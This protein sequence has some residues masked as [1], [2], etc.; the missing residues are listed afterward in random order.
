MDCRVQ[1]VRLRAPGLW[2]YAE[3]SR[4]PGE[5]RTPSSGFKVEVKGLGF[6]VEG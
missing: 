1:G 5:G 6:M 3:K 4:Q 2:E